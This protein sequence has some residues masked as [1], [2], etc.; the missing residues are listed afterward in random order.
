MK[1]ILPD[2]DRLESSDGGGG[3]GCCYRSDDVGSILCDHTY[4]THE[5]L[6]KVMPVD[7]LPSTSMSR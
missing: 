1:V 6:S 2:H 3:E 4:L 5:L 7:Q